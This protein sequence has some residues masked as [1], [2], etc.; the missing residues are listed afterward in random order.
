MISGKGAGSVAVIVEFGNQ[1]KTLSVNVTKSEEETNDEI[2][3]R[4]ENAVTTAC[5]FNSNISDLQKLTNLTEYIAEHYPYNASAGD[6]VNFIEDYVKKYDLEWG[7][8][9]SGSAET[10]KYFAED[11]LGLQAE[12]Y[13]MSKYDGGTHVAAYVVCNG[14]SYIFDAGFSGT[15]PRSWSVRDVS[16]WKIIAGNIYGTSYGN[17]VD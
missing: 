5:G 6:I 7:A 16:T 9:C 1:K 3:H 15:V 2:V 8:D 10:I 14:H 4:W 17:I 13:D 11:W 12:V